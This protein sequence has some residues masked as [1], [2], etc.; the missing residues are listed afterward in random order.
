MKQLNGAGGKVVFSMT[1]VM[2]SASSIMTYLALTTWSSSFCIWVS[3]TS[4][5]WPSG[6]AYSCF[7]LSYV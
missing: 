3:V 1:I 5:D 6:V 4:L 2:V 7:T